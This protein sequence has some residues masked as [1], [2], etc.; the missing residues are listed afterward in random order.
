LVPAIARRLRVFE[1]PQLTQED[2]EANCTDIA[3]SEL[4]DQSGIDYSAIARQV[5]KQVAS[6]M[7]S[8]NKTPL[9]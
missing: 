6:F 1:Y 7:F 2:L 3:L 5:T 8:L 4:Q 9:P